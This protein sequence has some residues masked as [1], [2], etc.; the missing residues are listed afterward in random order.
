M[1][2]IGINR[3]P[4]E[5]ISPASHSGGVNLHKNFFREQRKSSTAISNPDLIPIEEIVDRIDDEQASSER[6]ELN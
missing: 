6:R 1:N 4:S 2:N 3:E 5:K